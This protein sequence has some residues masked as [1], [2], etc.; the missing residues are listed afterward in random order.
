[1][2]KTTPTISVIERRLQSPNVFRASSQPIALVEPKKWTVRWENSEI[3]PEHLSDMIHV[4]GWVY[5][6]PA[7]LACPIEEIGA[8]VRDGR[9]VR[10]ERGREVLMKMALRDYSRVQKKKQEETIRQTF[11]R[12]QI[13]DAIVAGA[14]AEHGEQ[15]AE[16]LQQN[17]NMVSVQDSRGPEE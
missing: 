2:A 6:E 11:G 7:D 9:V 12:K 4:K 5:A 8:T 16:F 13:K 1:M 15:A 14:A 3:S 17:V 10:G